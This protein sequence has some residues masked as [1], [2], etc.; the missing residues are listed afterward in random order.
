MFLSIDK[1]INNDLSSP[2]YKKFVIR[3][4]DTLKNGVLSVLGLNFLRLC[5]NTC[6][7]Q[8]KFTA[9]GAQKE[10]VSRATDTCEMQIRGLG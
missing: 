3:H 7:P 6:I 5:V 1:Y 2:P 9:M 10:Y 4:Q 8:D